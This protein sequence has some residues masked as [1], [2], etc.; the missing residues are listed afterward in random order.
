[1]TASN[2][3]IMVVA[4]SS[5]VPQVELEMGLD[6]LRDLGFSVRVHPQT[7]R[8]HRFCAGTDEER[9][10]AFLEAAFDPESDIVWCA[11]GG[12][13]A[14]RILEKLDRAFARAKKKPR[15]KLFI[16]FSD[17]T[18]LHAWVRRRLGWLTLHGPMPGVRKFSAISND[19]FEETLACIEAA[20]GILAGSKEKTK[21]KKAR[22][23]TLNFEC[24]KA[25]DLSRVAGPQQK[26]AIK[27]GVD[28]GNLCVLA[29][30]CGTRFQPRFDR[31]I[32]FLEE[33]D[34]AWYRVDRLVQQLYDSKAF[35][36]TKAIVLGTFT[37]CSDK[38]PD[39]LR[40]RPVSGQ[41]EEKMPLRPVLSES[42]AIGAIFG[43]LSR[44]L[45]VPVYSGLK[46]GHGEGVLP[47]PLGAE[48][49][50]SPSGRFELVR[51]R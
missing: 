44:R 24:F 41:P 11:R 1:M 8:Q 15:R 30:M 13:G 29:A 31:K 43:D 50:L 48:Y 14:T 33:I 32:V 39:V 34:E 5:P 17:A 38:M 22:A 3:R 35:R 18:A 49:K 6:R 26:S 47:L 2:R 45:K 21:A 46:V 40:S 19:E 42:E 10:D 23:M 16:G 37:S 27:A 7:H 4:P 36:G 9:V 25:I 51:W 12:Y 28:G 20:E